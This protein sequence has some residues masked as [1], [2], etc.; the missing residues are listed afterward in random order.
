MQR[1]TRLQ[2]LIAA[3]LMMARNRDRRAVHNVFITP[4]CSAK[5]SCPHVPYLVR[6]AQLPRGQIL[7]ILKFSR[8]LE[9]IEFHYSK[10][11]I[12]EERLYEYDARESRRISIFYSLNATEHSFYEY[13]LIVL[14]ILFVH[15][16]IIRVQYSE[17][18][19][20]YKFLS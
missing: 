18:S 7:S 16:R 13:T 10:L 20:L 14:F 3:A 2:S 1:E 5:S 4:L 6:V 15:V 12:L 9:A 11:F 8:V 19:I 17:Y